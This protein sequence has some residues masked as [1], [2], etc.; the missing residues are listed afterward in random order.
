MGRVTVGT[1]HSWQAREMTK[2]VDGSLRLSQGS[3]VRAS[4]Y[5]VLAFFCWLIL[6]LAYKGL[7]LLAEN[8]PGGLILIAFLTLSALVIALIASTRLRA[9]APIEIHGDAGA[10]RFSCATEVFE[11]S[12][13][14]TRGAGSR[15]VRFEDVAGVVVRA[16]SD[17]LQ[18]NCSILLK[19]AGRR[20]QMVSPTSCADG[21]C[22]SFGSA[23]A[24]IGR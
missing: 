10:I 21:P 24:A 3:L 6:G 15:E 4:F 5:L 8:P 2:D 19:L 23:S 1:T 20:L 12:D 13:R 14:P 17:S 18:A 7:T 22:E 16:A 9:T 11:S